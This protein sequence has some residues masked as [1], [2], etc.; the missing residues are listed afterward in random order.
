MSNQE[1]VIWAIDRHRMA[2]DGRGVTTIVGLYGCPLA[3]KYC[4]NPEA[5]DERIHRKL[6]HPFTP[7]ALLEKV[8]VDDLYFRATNGGITFGGG[9]SLLYADFI[10]DFA[11]MCPKE[12]TI[13]AETSLYV[14]E[15]NFLRSLEGVNTYIV[16]IKD[17]SSDIYRAYTGKSIEPMLRN[18]ETLSHYTDTKTVLI[19]LPLIRDFN[20]PED[21]DRSEAKLKEMG[22][23]LFNRF[24]YTIR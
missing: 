22:F 21:V 19:R 5:R 13:T 24:T 7:E 10:A 2:T 15:E 4:I 8:R 6:S 14:S 16:D 1:A 18:L 23:T 20:T 3:C 11:H 17:M 12:W 9:E